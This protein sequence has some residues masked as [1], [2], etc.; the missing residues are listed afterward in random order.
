MS[1]VAVVDHDEPSV[2]MAIHHKYV[3]EGKGK[4]Q[5]KKKDM[6]QLC[7]KTVIVEG[8]RDILAPSVPMLRPGESSREVDSR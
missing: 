1:E 8:Q 5:E 4:E 3:S 7:P 2:H 6:Y